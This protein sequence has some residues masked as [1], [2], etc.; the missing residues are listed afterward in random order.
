MQVRSASQIPFRSPGEAR[1]TVTVLFGGDGDP[2]DVGLVR[3]TM[4]PG[5]EMPA[6]KHHG[7]D[8]IVS[9]ISGQ[10]QMHQG[11]DTIDLTVGDSVLVDKEEAVSLTNR[12]SETAELLVAAG[13][14]N[15]V[16]TVARWPLARDTAPVD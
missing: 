6:H 10:V 15:F 16:A 11:E 12:S 4:P 13:P 1:P 5:V 9:P 8:V 3:V 2:T 14:T 7:S